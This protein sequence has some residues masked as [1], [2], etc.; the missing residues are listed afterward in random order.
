MKIPKFLRKL[1]KKLFRT[2][3]RETNTKVENL[4]IALDKYAERVELVEEIQS[5]SI[6]KIQELQSSAINKSERLDLFEQKLAL[7]RKKQNNTNTLRVAFIFQHVS[8]WTTWKSVI[9]AFSNN[10][11]VIADIVLTPFIHANTST[12]VAYDNA[13]Q[14]LLEND[15]PY[16]TSSYYDLNQFVPDVVFVLNPYNETRPNYLQLSDFDS[17][18]IKVAYIPFGLEV[19]GGKWNIESQFNLSV[20][21]TAWRIFAR[22]SRHKKLFSKYCE[23]GDSHVCV[24]GHPKFDNYVNQPA[25]NA[26][27]ALVQKVNGRKV[28]LWTPH[29]AV[30]DPPT[31]STYQIYCDAILECLSKSNELFLIIRP[32]PLFFHSML[33]N[34][35][36]NSQDECEFRCKIEEA[37][38]LALDEEVD[39]SPVFSI[40]TALMTDAGSFLLEF[41][42]SEKPILYLH[43]PEG[44]GMNEDGN[45]LVEYLY[46][47]SNSAEMRDL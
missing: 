26:D 34:N 27:Q 7:L 30:G 12:S 38:N 40:A 20:Q 31:W 10:E 16:I 2:V 21:Q 29:F 19:G 37:D 33:S 3:C 15:I 17:R 14:F 45:D 24:T 18:Y 41:L 6:N 25:V 47:A 42:P 11:R 39:V 23:S 13:R 1:R 28:L 32:H 4:V 5:S 43:H 46:S 35:I 22:S 8:V 9:E 44:L 36:W